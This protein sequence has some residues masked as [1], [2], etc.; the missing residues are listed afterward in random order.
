MKKVYLIILFLT[1]FCGFSQTEEE[2]HK[3]LEELF[4]NCKNTNPNDIL[5]FYV[6]RKLGLMNKKT[7]QTLVNPIHTNIYI[8]SLSPIKG[9][10]SYDLFVEHYYTFSVDNNWKIS[11]KK[12][13]NYSC[14]LHSPP[15]KK[16]RYEFVPSDK[17]SKGFQIK[18][19]TV[20]FAKE[21]ESCN[22][23]GDNDVFKYK[24][25]YYLIVCKKVEDGYLY[26]IIDQ[27]GNI[28]EHFNYKHSWIDVNKYASNENDVWLKVQDSAMSKNRVMSFINMSGEEKL[29]NQV[30]DNGSISTEIFGYGITKHPID[31]KNG[32]LDWA[33]MQWVIL[34]QDKLVF[35]D[36]IIETDKKVNRHDIKNRTKYRILISTDSYS[37]SFY[38]DFSEKKFLPKEFDNQ[39]ENLT[40]EAFAQNKIKDFFKDYDANT[41]GNILYFQRGFDTG[42]I[43]AETMEE[44]VPPS[45]SPILIQGELSTPKIKGNFYSHNGFFEF[46][47]HPTSGLELK[48][49]EKD[50]LFSKVIDADVTTAYTSE[51]HKRVTPNNKNFEYVDIITHNENTYVL[52]RKLSKENPMMGIIDK[53]EEI[54]SPF[55]FE[56]ETIEQNTYA[57]DNIWFLTK[58]KGE[59]YSHFTSISGDTKTL[60]IKEIKKKR[61]GYAIAESTDNTM[62][63]IDLTTIQWVI[64]PQKQLHFVDFRHTSKE[65][66][67]TQNI[68]NRTKAMLYILVHQNDCQYFIDLKGKKYIPEKYLNK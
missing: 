54:L 42:Y 28:S 39:E 58:K 11:T 16:P 36:L 46:E 21:Y 17:L 45:G 14:V 49:I 8:Q 31:K 63:V 57:K 29:K 6:D 53:K 55:E 50:D 32:V 66:I 9:K 24:G 37:K 22:Y 18:N 33:T 60:F 1:S 27:Q 10:V 3:E 25:K 48:R 15:Y 19:R 56:Y 40:A 23:F 41:I 30:P 4:T 35:K 20:F 5:P 61:L 43:D 68:E 34:P 13:I 2:V 52:A 65:E 51:K 62:G 7:M 64:K 12:E 47:Y 67:D 38:M 59:E 26:A 44:I